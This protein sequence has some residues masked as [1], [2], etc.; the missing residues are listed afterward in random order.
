MMK[1]KD[2]KANEFRLKL[3]RE[4]KREYR[5]K[6]NE[7]KENQTPP[8]SAE[9]SFSSKSVKCRRLKRA[10]DAWPKSP[11]KRHEIVQSL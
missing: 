7:A 5:K 10:V 2:P 3:Q 6:V 9:F 4:Q 1:V 8:S 11:N